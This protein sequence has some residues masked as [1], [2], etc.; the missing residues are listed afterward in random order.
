[1]STVNAL[2]LIPPGNDGDTALADPFEVLIRAN[3]VVLNNQ[4]RDEATPELS[5]Q[6]LQAG[7]PPSA[8]AYFC[9]PY[10]D[11]YLGLQVR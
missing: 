3:N 11:S 5:K 10:I 1:M 6:L 4:R 7:K 2:A 8:H 9:S